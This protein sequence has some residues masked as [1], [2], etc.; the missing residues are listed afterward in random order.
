VATTDRYYMP[1]FSD[2]QRRSLAL[3]PKLTGWSSLVFSSFLAVHIL[4]QCPQ[5]ISCY[6]RLMLGVS[7]ADISA[8]FWHGMSTWPIP[9][10]KALWA[11]GTDTTCHLQGFFTQNSI[12]SSFYNASLS[13]YFY[14]VIVRHWKEDELQRIER[15]WLHGIPLLAGLTTSILGLILGVYGDALLWCWVSD[16]YQVFRWAA[17]YGPLWTNIFMVTAC[18]TAIYQHVRQL[19]LQN[20]NITT[21]TAPMTPTVDGTIH[22]TNFSLRER[23]SVHE[24]GEEEQEQEEEQVMGQPSAINDV[25]GVNQGVDLGRTMGNHNQRTDPEMAQREHQQQHHLYTMH[26]RRVKQVAQQCFLYSAAFYVNWSSLTAVR[27]IQAFGGK[28]VPYSLILIS[29]ITVPIQGL[30]NFLVF[31]RPKLLAAYRKWR[32]GN[33]HHHNNGRTVDSSSVPYGSR[34]YG[35]DDISMSRRHVISTVTHGDIYDDDNAVDNSSRERKNKKGD[36][37]GNNEGS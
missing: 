21:R 26:Q 5:Q 30:P 28:T 6:H 27:L 34:R 4:R 23:G 10:N 1:D 8:S 2:T 11:V 37:E 19:E 14:L 3:L 16:E 32:S 31:L 17:Y 35:E 18:C 20:P 7:A 12:I 36:E 13:V 33:N 25:S 9:R 29:A 15:V 22:T 24:L